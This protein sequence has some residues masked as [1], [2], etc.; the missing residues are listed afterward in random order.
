MSDK[1]GPNT[2]L[3]EAFITKL[4]TLTPQQWAT[5]RDAARD[6]AGDAAWYAAGATAGAAAWAVRALV[7]KDLITTEQ[8]DILYKP[9]AEAIPIV[10]IETGFVDDTVTIDAPL[11]TCAC[12]KTEA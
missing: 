3:V 8:F 1:Y 10:S 2:K 6:A 9:F 12:H 4:R 11:C 7:V 5:A